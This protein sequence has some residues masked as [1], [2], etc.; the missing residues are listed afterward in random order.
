MQAGSV[1]LETPTCFRALDWLVTATSS[2][3]SI[4]AADLLTS[5]G[6][7]S[8]SAKDAAYFDSLCLPMTDVLP[9]LR[10]ALLPALMPLLSSQPCCVALLEDSI[11]QFGVPFDSF[12]VDAVSRVVDVVCSSQY[13]GFQD[14]SQLCGFTLLSSV[15]AMSSGNLQQLAWTVLNAVQVPNDQGHQAAKGG[16]ITTTRNVSTTLFVAP[17]LPDACVTPINALL[18]WAS[19]MP[20][21]T[22]TVIDTDLTLAALFEDDQ[23]LPGRTALDAFVQA[24]PQSLSNDMY[25]M[26]S[27]LLTNDNVCFHLANSYATGSDAFETTVSSFTQ[28]LDLGS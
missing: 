28:S 20:V 8:L 12:V 15:L 3:P 7:A 22:S 19:K 13:P 14:E 5:S 24:F 21:V 1:V 2:Y 17:N 25:S 23:C 26:A 11:A 27:A 9:C 18:K 4:T 10:R 6:F 16:S